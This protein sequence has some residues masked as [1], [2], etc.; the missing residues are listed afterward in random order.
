MTL[1]HLVSSAI[2]AVFDRAFAQNDEARAA[3]TP[4]AGG[5]LRCELASPALTV[6][7]LV[8][9]TSLEVLSVTDGDADAVLQTDLAG[10]LALSR[11]SDALLSGKARVRGSLRLVE[12]VHR[13][14]TLL[15]VDWEDQ[16]A[17]VL[18]DSLAHKLAGVVDRFTRDA[19]RNRGRDAADVQRYLQDELGVLVTQPAWRALTDDTDAVRADIDRL[20]ARLARLE[21]GT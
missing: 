5:L 1:P 6:D 11:G 4:H 20:E 7:V 21:A 10:L 19:G 17:P 16:L 14:V 9:E 18:G 8:L 15:A 2:S 3:L 13:A 12:G